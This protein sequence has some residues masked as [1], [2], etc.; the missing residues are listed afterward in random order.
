MDADTRHQLKSNELADMLASLKDLKKPQY[1]YPGLAVLAVV[2]AVVA[3][4]GWR[5]SQR[6]AAEQDW[7]RLDRIVTSLTFGDASAVS[8][9]QS[10]LRAMLQDKLPP[11]VLGYA[12]IELARSRAEQGL[13]QATER[14]AAFEDA[15]KLLEEV[16][17]DPACPPMQQA[18]ATFLLASTYESL[19]Q[20]DRAKE[21]YESLVQ[22]AR[23]AGSPYKGL[24]EQRLTDIDQVSKPIAFNPGEA[25]PP[26]P[27]ATQSTIL[28]P[29][30]MGPPAGPTA[31]PMRLTPLSHPPGQPPA[32]PAPQ[33][34]QTPNPPAPS[35]QPP[36][37]TPQPP[38]PSPPQPQPGPETPPRSHPTP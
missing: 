37:P 3:W 33:S 7:Q 27:P 28:S 20:F 32:P 9:A 34:P 31:A 30:M 14:P 1:L 26:P 2:V 23:Y 19:R 12:R 18:E 38:N 8:G 36:T 6:V 35:P 16:R 13:A 21:T 11:S 10:E 4:Y 17:S 5:Y 22:D 25:P 15:A 24:A 29:D